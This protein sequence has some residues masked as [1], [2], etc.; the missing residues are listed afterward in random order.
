MEHGFH[1]TAVELRV[2]DLEEVVPFYEDVV[3]LRTLDRTASRVSLGAGEDGPALV[4]L[5][6]DPDAPERPRQAAGLFHAA[7]RL[8]S[9]EALSHALRRI[10]QAGYTL[11]GA[12]DHRVSEALYLEDPEG[13]GLELYV[14]RPQNQWPRRADGRVVMDTLGLDRSE[15]RTLTAQDEIAGLPAGTDLGHVHLEV[16]DLGRALR[17]YRDVLGME[18]RSRRRGAHFLAHRDYH[19]HVAI[20]T[21]RQRTEPAARGA[22]GLVAVHASLTS[23]DAADGII[24][25]AEQDHRAEAERDDGLVR[26]RDLDGIEW[27]LSV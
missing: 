7:I 17:V 10:E 25:R 1:L 3:G 23:E 19:H 20:N 13:N 15:L 27:R 4:I 11:Q 8:P 21:W 24:S 18:E 22:L 14:D 5:D 9:R 12:S 26:L 16:T 6:E 2:R